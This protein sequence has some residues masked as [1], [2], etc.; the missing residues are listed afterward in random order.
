MGLLA[1]YF[2]GDLTEEN[3]LKAF[4]CGVGIVLCSCI[5]TVV[6]AHN[7][8]KSQEAGEYSRSSTYV[9]FKNFNFVPF[10]YGT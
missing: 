7:I 10:L 8:M 4:L 2:V 6:H 1:E 3:T 9:C 5:V